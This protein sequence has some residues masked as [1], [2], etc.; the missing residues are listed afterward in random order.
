MLAARDRAKRR[1]A[2]AGVSATT[3]ARVPGAV[4]RRDF[5]ADEEG[6]GVISKALGDGII[7]QRGVDRIL[8]LAWTVADVG[9]VG[10]PRLAE[11]MDALDL[12]ATVEAGGAA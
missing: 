5:P 4:L 7:T 6:M 9:G 8:R 10:K 11:V 3:N 12:R 1:W 2:K